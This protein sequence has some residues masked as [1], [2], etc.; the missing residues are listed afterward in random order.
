[1]YSFITVEGLSAVLF[2]AG[3]NK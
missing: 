1:M 2:N 3:C